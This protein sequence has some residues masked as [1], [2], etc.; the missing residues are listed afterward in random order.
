MKISFRKRGV[1]IFV[2]GILLTGCAGSPSMLAPHGAEAA[3][4]AWLTWFMFAIA[5]IVLIVISVLLWKAYKRSQR[6]VGEEDL[7][8]NDR[9]TL[10]N[11]VVG[12][13]AVPIVVLLVV[14]GLGIG[15]ERVNNPS[16]AGSNQQI[17]I[18]VIGHQWWWEIHYSHENFNTANEIH[19]P[20]GQPV[21]I[22]VTS[23][24]II[25]SF[26]VPELHG[27]IDLIP[28]Q[29]NTIA[30]EADTGH[31]PAAEESAR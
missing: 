24:D 10:R 14:M 8:G 6:E 15:I 11:V 18:E 12:G 5:A 27:K 4:V 31:F 9:S 3:R 28:G 23:A 21:T 25:H 13:G 26:W 29:T 2:T 20:V 17:D 1:L 30:I 19:I 7:Y 16:D 22:R